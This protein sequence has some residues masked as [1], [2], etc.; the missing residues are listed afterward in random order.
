MSLN[1]STNTAAARAGINLA[2]NSRLLQK[3]FD[4]L[5]SGRQTQFTN[6]RPWRVGREHET[7]SINQPVERSPEQCA[8]RDILP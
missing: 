2:K 7:A 3:S 1:I 6:G 5:A 8:K 4:R